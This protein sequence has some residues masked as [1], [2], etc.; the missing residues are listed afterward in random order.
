MLKDSIKIKDSE[1]SGDVINGDKI[2]YGIDEDKIREIIGSQFTLQRTLSMIHEDELISIA[3]D[4]LNS[5]IPP[6]LLSLFPEANE[7][8]VNAITFLQTE[9]RHVTEFA[10]DKN[11]NTLKFNEI[12]EA[13]G[14]AHLIVASGGTGKTHA[15]WN[16]GNELIKTSKLFPI[17]ISLS[18]FATTNEV[19]NFIE[20]KISTNDLRSITKNPSV[21]FLLDG[22]SQFPKN[23][24][25]ADD[26]ERRKL[27]SLLGDRKIIATARYTNQYDHRFK[28]WTLEGLS[29]VTISSAISVACP[30]SPEIPIE[31]KD[32]L[33]LPLALILYLLMGGK[34]STRGELISAFHNQLTGYLKDCETLNDILSIAV[35]RLTLFTDS[36]KY[37]DFYAEIKDI[38]RNRNVK[39]V[40]LFIE[41]LGTLGNRQDKIQPIHDLYWDWLVGCG[42][43]NDWSELS[44]YVAQ[45]LNS[46]EFV[47]LALESGRRLCVE[48]V[49][50]LLDIDIIFVAIFI[51]YL[52]LK[53]MGEKQTFNRFV[54][55][56]DELLSSE[57]SI[58]QYRGVIGAITSKNRDLLKKALKAISNLS[59]QGYYLHGLETIFDV[60]L[61]WE[62]REIVSAWL[63]NSKGKHYLLDSIQN[64]RQNKWVDWLSDQL[65]KGKLTRGEA[66]Q[67]ALGCT[68]NLPIWIERILP[69]LIKVDLGAYYLRSAAKRGDNFPLAS[70]VAEHYSEYV[71]TITNSIWCDLNSILINCGNDALFD[72]ISDEI[73]S[74]APHLQEVLLFVLIE[75]GDE[76]IGRLQSMLFRGDLKQRYHKLYE[77]VYTVVSDA[78]A[79]EWAES[80]NDKLSEYGWS[81]L[82]KRHQNA[83]LTEL[84]SNLPN[85]FSNM[86]IIP[87]LKAM[88]HLNSPPESLINELWK[89]LMGNVQPMVMD[90]I[91]NILS[92]IMP[93][94]IPSVIGEL[95]RNPR[96][97][98]SYHVAQFIKY[99]KEWQEK[100]GL[101]IR[102]SSKYGETE[103]SEFL[104]LE[105][106]AQNIDDYFVVRMCKLESSNL[107]LDY[108]TG[109]WEKSKLNVLKIIRNISEYKCYH[110][111]IVLILFSLPDGE[112][113]KDIINLFRNALY[114]FPEAMLFQILKAI[115]ELNDQSEL[116]R[117]LI[118]YISLNPSTQHI[119]FHTQLLSMVISLPD[120][121]VYIYG[122]LSKI[123]A[124]Y[125][126]EILHSKL[127]SY[128][129]ECNYNA[130][131][132]IRYIESYTKKLLINERGQ[133]IHNQ[134]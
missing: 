12:V 126:D 108:I 110:E 67:A 28:I 65:Q 89:R 116:F 43:F 68:D 49:K 95:R 59:E 130:I 90:D 31:L 39:G 3:K 17:F 83:I 36:R 53:T 13:E 73:P 75:T 40:K 88:K 1:V 71:S 101:R 97:L 46:R 69:D 70:W 44:I 120:K 84:I 64:S 23:V 124:I 34:V 5:S 7:Y 10:K 21:I 9:T 55:K 51:P 87:T 106:I 80:K 48:D 104:V 22:W 77:K 93:N 42:V 125:P 61:L 102:T 92:K 96:L 99:L 123:L 129:D 114:T 94:G 133:W 26:S 132:I 119:N 122:Y 109:F 18:D 33:K 29:E 20:K 32:L 14:N 57:H 35:A 50:S 15:L 24:P 79:R 115:T 113:I 72:L 134:Y 117:L 66:V 103:F 60:E 63:E 45:F 54:S 127:Q 105:N 86:H 8:T 62:N 128:L 30:D 41:Q 56:I 74:L 91:L 121:E 118:H 76:R 47:K 19:V 107:V 81:V 16:F 112:G 131:S 38:E 37:S 52:R 100:T 78:Q 4:L 111:G 2:T 82:A 27:L 85:S 58:Q 6:S 11:A 98:P 25:S